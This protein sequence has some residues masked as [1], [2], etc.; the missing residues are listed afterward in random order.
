MF[1]R[2]SPLTIPEVTV[3]CSP[4][5]LPIAT[6]KSPTSSREESPSASLTPADIHH[7]LTGANFADG[8]QGSGALVRSVEPGSPA[9]QAGLRGNDLI[10]GVNQQ[11]VDSVHTLQQRSQG[12]STLVLEVRRGNTIVLVP[13]H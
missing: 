1:E 2:P 13:V 12:A 3:F 5:G 11:P 8:E 7:G 4:K 10:V 6:T 9:A